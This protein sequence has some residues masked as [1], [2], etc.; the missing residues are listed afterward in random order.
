MIRRR[1]AS[2]KLSRPLAFAA[3]LALAL[4]CANAAHAGRAPINAEHFEPQLDGRGLFNAESPDALQQWQWGVGTML[5]YARNPLVISDGTRKRLGL[6]E[7]RVMMN[8]MASLALTDWLTVGASLPVALINEQNAGL[9]STG[10]GVTGLG[11]MRLQ[12]KFRILDEARHHIGV[13][14]I[15][16]AT[17]PTGNHNAFLGQNGV[18]FSPMLAIE[19]H[20]GPVRAL[21]NVGYTLREE[22]RYFNIV[23]DDELFWRVALGVRVHE[24]VEVGAELNGATAAA[25]LF[26]SNVRRNPLEVLAGARVLLTDRLQL[27]GG[28]GPGLSTGYGTPTFRF[29]AGVLFA[30]HERDTDGDGLIDSKDRCPL[31]PGPRE[32]QG[33]PWPDTDGDGLTDNVDACPTTPGPKENK[34]CPWPDSDG[35]G[36]LDKDDRC[37]YLRGPIENQGCPWPDR[38]TDGVLDKDDGCPDVPG[39]AENKGCPWPD[40]DSDGVLDKD[41]RCPDVPGPKENQGCPVEPPKPSDRDGD[42]ILDADDACPDV[43]GPKENQGCPWPDTDKD[44]VVDCRDA[45]PACARPRRPDSCPKAR[46]AA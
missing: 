17:L 32:N 37:P 8:V 25:E 44:G 18:A 26:G 1:P 12:L 36:I 14:F 41:D 31:V 5:H 7:D 13:A 28:A 29:F 22:T 19:R 24:K 11:S 30:P 20:F 40:R 21:L 2:S 38:D 3:A 9:A 34:G 35:D 33:C 10:V 46:T 39:P 27:Y 23:V 6:V 15:P 16:S 42:G 4:C 45:R 43:P